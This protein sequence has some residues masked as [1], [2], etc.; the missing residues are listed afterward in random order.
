VDNKVLCD[1]GGPRCTHR[2]C[3]KKKMGKYSGSVQSAKRR[4]CRGHSAEGIHGDRPSEEEFISGEERARKI[5]LPSENRKNK[6]I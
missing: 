5:H 6:S 3:Y 2:E 1:R 4:G